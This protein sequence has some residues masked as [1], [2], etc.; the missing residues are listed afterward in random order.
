MKKTHEIK[1]YD[2]TRKGYA[3]LLEDDGTLANASR[4]VAMLFLPHYFNKDNQETKLKGYDA[5]IVCANLA[6]FS[7]KT[8]VYSGNGKI[9]IGKRFPKHRDQSFYS[10]LFSDFKTE[11]EAIQYDPEDEHG[12]CDETVK[13]AN[14]V[15]K[16]KNLII[17][18]RKKNNVIEKLKMFFSNI[19]GK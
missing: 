10:T 15:Y 2:P 13:V 16:Y 17:I 12:L 9:K 4:D 6:G 11:V 18:Q 14:L 5:L 19:F 3:E 7:V 8:F 1:I